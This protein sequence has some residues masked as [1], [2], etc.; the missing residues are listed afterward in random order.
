MKR[1]GAQAFCVAK[2][3]SASRDVSTGDNYHTTKR[4][5]G[6]V[7]SPNQ[8]CI[9]IQ[10]V[11]SDVSHITPRRSDPACRKSNGIVSTT[12]SFCKHRT[13]FPI[14]DSLL[15][16]LDFPFPAES[17]KQKQS[18]ALFLIFKKLSDLD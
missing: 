2:D 9:Q 17:I 11:L 4:T 10:H 14:P 5:R 15:S 16:T 3:Q 13:R 6:P 1:N 7:R 8:D 12:T 18:C